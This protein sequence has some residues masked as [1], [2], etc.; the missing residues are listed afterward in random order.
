[1]GT[2]KFQEILNFRKIIPVNFRVKQS[3]IAESST[4]LPVT[5][6]QIL[7]A[8]KLLQMEIAE[9]HLQRFDLRAV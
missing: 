3:H 4:Q 2:T 1:M 9:P 6:E 7:A 5:T 8:L